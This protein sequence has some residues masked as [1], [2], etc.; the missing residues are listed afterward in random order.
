MEQC[1]GMAR[2]IEAMYFLNKIACNMFSS[3]DKYRIIGRNL[4]V[5][6]NLKKLSGFCST[7][8]IFWF[9]IVATAPSEPGPPHL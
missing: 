9:V 2:N 5:L 3:D 8:C 7:P 6:F 1:A 4:I